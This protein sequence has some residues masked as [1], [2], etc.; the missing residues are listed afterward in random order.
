MKATVYCEPTERGVHSF[1]L[2]TDSTE[3]YLF[4]QSYRKGVQNYYGRGV[5]LEEATDF[6]RTHHDN[7]IM[8]TMS[9]LPM[10]IRYIEKEYDVEILEKTKKRNK[11]YAHSSLERCA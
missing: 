11:R 6:S 2:V 9:K 5:R 7:A 8:R 4:S 1:F 3:Y 10:Y